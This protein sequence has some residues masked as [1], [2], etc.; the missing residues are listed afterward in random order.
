MFAIKSLAIGSTAAML[1][2]VGAPAASAASG[3]EY[4]TNSFGSSTNSANSTDWS[5]WDVTGDTYTSVSAAWTV[6][7][8]T[9][10]AGETSY[11]ADWVGLDGDGSDSVEQTGTSSDCDSGT[12]AYS[13]WYEF[14]PSISVNLPNLVKAGDKI[15][16]AV[17][18]EKGT[19]QFKLVL[20]DS[21]Q[22][23]TKTQ[24]GDSPAGTGASAEIIAEAPSGSERTNSVLP[25]ADFKTVTFSDVLVNG[26]KL[27]ATAGAAKI[28]MVDDY[29]NPM[30]TVSQLTGADSF[31]VTWVSSGAATVSDQSTADQNPGT[32]AG[33]YG[34][35]G[36]QSGA[37]GYGSTGADGAGSAD[38]WGYSGGWGYPDGSGGITG[39]NG[40][41][42]TPGE[43]YGEGTT[44]S[45]GTAAGSAG[46]DSS[47]DGY[48]Y[49][50]S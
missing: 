27:A 9:C 31:T 45:S 21:T 6:P 32:G 41:T 37:G 23:W 40:W 14:Y 38:G 26:N 20:T 11:S 10:A 25:L 19:D 5:G 7:T 33:G 49:W 43:G 1:I 4:A 13:A 47:G 36:A 50:Q 12:A 24:T 8:V 42:I 16:A 2:A 29:A 35:P 48:T 34:W 17:A 28:A 3:V 46:S 18:S 39:S 15:S 44:E 22:K 30:A